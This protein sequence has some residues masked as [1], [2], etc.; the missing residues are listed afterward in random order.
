VLDLDWIAPAGPSDFCGGDALMRRCVLEEVGGYD[1]E[2]IAGEEPEMCRRMRGKG[3]VILHV[4]LPMTGHDMAM[5]RWSQY[6]RRATR[7]GYAY[8]EVSDRF[9]GSGLPFWE[10]EVRHNRKRA[11][12]LLLALFGSIA[13]AGLLR[14]P[15]PA[16]LA[17]AF[18]VLISIRTAQRNA[19][20]SASFATRFLYGLHSHFQQIPILVGQWQRMRDRKAGLKRGLIEYKGAGS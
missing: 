6:W 7:T 15:W 2:L 9:R 16:A 18:Y 20:K 19:W 8:L 3:H 4:D 14:S 11:A 1:Q 10:Y 17:P 13:L 12:I 5:K